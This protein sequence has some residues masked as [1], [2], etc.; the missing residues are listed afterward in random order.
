MTLKLYNYIYSKFTS[1]LNL[2]GGRNRMGRITVPH[3]VL[4]V[5][6]KNVF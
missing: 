4:N 1:R 5:L 3:R 6:I 2:K